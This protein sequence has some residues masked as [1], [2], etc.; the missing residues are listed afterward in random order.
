MYIR[1]DAEETFLK[2]YPCSQNP[3]C[4]DHC[5]VPC[6]VSVDETSLYM[7]GSQDVELGEVAAWVDLC[8]RNFPVLACT[9][10][11]SLLCGPGHRPG[12]LGILD[13]VVD[14]EPLATWIQEFL[15]E[16]WESVSDEERGAAPGESRFTSA[17]VILRQWSTT[18]WAFKATLEID[19]EKEPYQQLVKAVPDPEYVVYMTFRN[20]NRIIADGPRPKRSTRKCRIH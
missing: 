15:T 3:S 14:R 17:K 6:D 5:T 8:S 11:F 7:C 10:A 18:S 9:P 4:S 1:E 20:L 12:S 2:M 19:L 13:M 16:R